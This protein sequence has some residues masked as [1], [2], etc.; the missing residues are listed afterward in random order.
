[1]NLNLIS[2]INCNPSATRAVCH[3]SVSS[4]Y[5]CFS[6][7]HHLKPWPHH[8]H[9]LI[10]SKIVLEET[11]QSIRSWVQTYPDNIG[12]SHI[13]FVSYQC[14]Y[15]KKSYFIYLWIFYDKFLS[16]GLKSCFTVESSPPGHTLYCVSD[17][18][19]CQDIDKQ[20]EKQIKITGRHKVG[21]INTRCRRNPLTRW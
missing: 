10:N 17:P 13:Y 6:F 11:I 14:V 16:C 1:M 4:F 19:N 15:E 8:S 5:F 18:E 20:C 7:S 21:Q 9:I 12:R 3:T 2:L